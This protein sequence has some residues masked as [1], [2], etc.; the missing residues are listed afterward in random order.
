MPQ[1][2]AA[3]PM[4]R[5]IASANMPS[6][7]VIVGPAAAPA[8]APAAGAATAIAG[9]K[10]ATARNR[11]EVMRLMMW[12]PLETG[13]SV[14]GMLFERGA[15]VHDRQQGEDEGLDDGDQDAE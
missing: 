14:F 7:E 13:L 12:F 2:S 4:P 9:T 10:N 1:P 11:N 15:D 5:P 8:G 3:R 6:T